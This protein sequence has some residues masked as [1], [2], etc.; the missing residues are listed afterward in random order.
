MLVRKLISVQKYY[1]LPYK[2]KKTVPNPFGRW[3][4][5][6]LLDIKAV[7]FYILFI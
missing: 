2:H 7:K 6:L 5:F 3:N 4:R 1:I